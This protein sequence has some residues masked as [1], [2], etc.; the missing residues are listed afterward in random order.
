MACLPTVLQR[1]RLR[2]ATAS[3][4]ACIALQQPDWGAAVA[5]ATAGRWLRSSRRRQRTAA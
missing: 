4:C 5:R 3:K 2:W 1:L